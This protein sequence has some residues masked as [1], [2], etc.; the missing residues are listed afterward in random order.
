M[1]PIVA[2]VGRPN[3]GKSTLFNR[4]VGKNLAIVHDMPGV[5]RDRHYADA[6]LAGRKL[7]LIDTGGFDPTSDD[8]MNAGIARNVFTAIEEA[9]VVVCVFDGSG[10]P[11]E[12]DRD[13]VQL[14]RQS[15][16]PVIYVANKV[17]AREHEFELGPL[18]ELGL[19]RLI[20]VSSLHGRGTAELG[21]AI[22][23]ML[24]DP[25]STEAPPPDSPP[26]V[27]LIGRPNAGKSSLFNALVGEERSLVDSRPGTTRDP[28]DERIEFDGS[29]MLIVDTAGIRRRSRVERGL[30]LVSVLRAIR[31][32]ERAEVCILMCD[33]SEGVTEQ[34]ARLFSLVMERRRGA[35]VGLNK[36]DLLDGKARKRAIEQAEET[37]R[38]ASFAPIVPISA[39]RKENLPNLMR[40]TLRAA[41][42]MRHRIPTG[43]LNRFFEE[44]LD[45]RPPP[46]DGGRAP[47]IY[48]IR[49]VEAMPPVFVASASHV[50][51]LKESYQR[52]VINQMRE[53]FGFEGV[54][55]TVHYREHRRPQ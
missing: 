11:T 3:V 13:A 28:I 50:K 38:F 21:Q 42:Q 35:I 10:P 33:A 12:P 23:Q 55:I 2:I 47:R 7:T 36:M 20:P 15:G 40:A 39:H 1:T 34:D 44:V 17:D 27:A 24:P 41:E 32:M 37:L 30:E 25:P 22:R 51:H 54:P 5:T 9:D 4:L 16:K 6:H 19:P 53:H 8:P 46:T 52:F 31:A 48:Y 14:L 26:R 49:Q 43:E 29:P 18:Y 45:K